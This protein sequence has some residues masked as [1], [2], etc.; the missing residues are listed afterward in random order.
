MISVFCSSWFHEVSRG[1]HFYFVVHAWKQISTRHTKRFF[2]CI[3]GFY[4]YKHILTEVSNFKA[5]SKEN[6]A[7]ALES[8]Y[9]FS[10]KNFEYG[11][12]HDLDSA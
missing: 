1:T 3:S 7:V 11:M 10:K 5:L 6:Y 9:I 8:C 4:N 12:E 2:T